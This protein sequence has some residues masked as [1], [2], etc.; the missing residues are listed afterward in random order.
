MYRLY[1]EDGGLSDIH[2]RGQSPRTCIFD[3]PKSEL[4]NRFVPECGGVSVSYWFIRN[5]SMKF[6][7][8]NGGHEN[9]AVPSLDCECAVAICTKSRSII[10]VVLN[11]SFIP[12]ATRRTEK[13]TTASG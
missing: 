3:D 13:M 9:A 6:I 5:C 2:D 1:N 7:R 11:N 10:A 12:L 8:E 4:Y